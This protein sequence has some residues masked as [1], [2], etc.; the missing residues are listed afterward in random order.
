MLRRRQRRLLPESSLQG[1]HPAQQAALTKSRKVFAQHGLLAESAQEQHPSMS[2]KN[3]VQHVKYVK[4]G[5]W[6]YFV[7]TKVLFSHSDDKVK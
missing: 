2:K 5:M 1:L 6:F 7:P 4:N 3:A